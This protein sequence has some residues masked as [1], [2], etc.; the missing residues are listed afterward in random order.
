MNQAM[1]WL[2]AL[3]PIIF[4]YYREKGEKKNHKYNCLLRDLSADIE[5]FLFFSFWTWHTIKTGSF[6]LQS[7]EC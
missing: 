4:M 6:I 3:T 2:L 7:T 1:K 5:M